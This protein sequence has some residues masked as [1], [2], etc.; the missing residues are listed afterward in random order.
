M[1][2][3]LASMLRVPFGAVEDALHSE[4]AA[5]ATLSRRGLLLAGATALPVLAMGNLF[6]DIDWYRGYQ[7]FWVSPARPWV[8]GFF[9]TPVLIE[10]DSPLTLTGGMFTNGVRIIAPVAHVSC[11]RVSG[12]LPDID[13]AMKLEFRE[14]G[15]MVSNCHIDLQGTERKVAGIEI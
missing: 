5:K 13:C 10:G 3:T 2:D 15:G 11:M 8:G 7:K 1:W 6:S 14:N 4:R 9:D 12:V